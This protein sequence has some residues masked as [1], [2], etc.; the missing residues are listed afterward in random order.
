ME[1]DVFFSGILGIVIFFICPWLIFRYIEKKSRQL[2]EK[3][4]TE[5]AENNK[6]ETIAKY[7]ELIQE[8]VEL[9]NM[10]KYILEKSHLFYFCEDEPYIISRDRSIFISLPIRDS[11]I[12][13]FEIVY[14]NIYNEQDLKD[15]YNNKNIADCFYLDSVEGCEDEHGYTVAYHN[16]SF[17][18]YIGRVQRNE[19][20]TYKWEISIVVGEIL[21]RVRSI[22]S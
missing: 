18:G 6:N 10:G 13:N 20:W 3:I 1:N 22:N 16:F 15:Y 14:Q 17:V 11:D 2:S 9:Y 7:K 21:K 19:E 5:R 12:Q 8:G 4:K